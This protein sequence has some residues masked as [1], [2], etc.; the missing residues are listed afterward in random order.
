MYYSETMKI[1]MFEAK[2]IMTTSFAS[3]I[4]LLNSR[5]FP[6]AGRKMIIFKELSEALEEMFKFLE[7]SKNSRSKIVC[8]VR[9]SR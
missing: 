9:G 8:Y 6:E 2:V 5:N 7:F 3:L 1:H 4:Q